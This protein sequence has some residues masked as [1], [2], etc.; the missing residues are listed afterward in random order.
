[1]KPSERSNDKKKLVL[2]KKSIKVL[3]GIRTGLGGS[4]WSAACRT[5]TC[6]SYCFN[7]CHC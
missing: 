3:T 2:N 7:T 1:V 4:S 6:A 5:V